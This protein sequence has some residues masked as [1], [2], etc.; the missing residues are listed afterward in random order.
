MPRHPLDPTTTRTTEGTTHMYTLQNVSKTYRQKDRT[1]TE[2]LQ[3]LLPDLLVT[4]LRDHREQARILHVSGGG[5]GAIGGE[6]AAV[7][8]RCG[9]RSSA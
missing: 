9:Q 4:K 7:Y 2:V 1:I 5:N 3:E 6:P 8:I